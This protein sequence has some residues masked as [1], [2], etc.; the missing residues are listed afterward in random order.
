LKVNEEQRRIQAINR[1]LAGEK[2]S[3]IYASLGRSNYWFFKWLARFESGDENW[4]KSLPRAPKHPHRSTDEK[5]EKLIVSIRERLENTRYAQV[6]ADA[7]CWELT[8][9]NVEPPPIWTINRILKRHGLTKKKSK[10]YQPK[11]KAYPEIAAE[12]PNTIH[13]VDMV[14]PRFLASKERF[15]LLNVMDIARHK[16][17][18]NPI[19]L[20]NA[21]WVITSLLESWQSLGIPCFAQFDNQQVF[22]GTERRPRWFSRVIRLCLSL[23]IEPLFIPFGEPWR[24]GTI[25]KFNDT[26]DKMFFRSQHFDGFTHLTREAHVFEDFHNRNHRYSFLKGATPNEVEVRCAFAPRCIP[27]GFTFE[28]SSP[29]PD[30]K[31]HLVRFI[32]S[33]RMLNVFGEKFAVD[34]SCQYEYVTATIYVKEQMLR[35]LLFDNLIQ[36]MHYTIP[37]R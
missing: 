2:P 27:S 14:G 33:D 26:W 21:N 12:R 28:E 4:Y 5:L 22:C 36:E 30:G 24:N 9:M 16:V 34:P 10:G 23:G 8:K 31:I 37:K 18:I 13:Q 29:L 3:T 20:R 11:G 6:G 1:H 17:K 32:R 19:A 35:V 7:I 15:Y 25:E